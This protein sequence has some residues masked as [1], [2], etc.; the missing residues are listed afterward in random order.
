ML[1]IVTAKIWECMNISHS[2]AHCCY[3]TN[4]C[5]L[6][7]IS[8]MGKPHSCV[9]MSLFRLLKLNTQEGKILESSFSSSLLQSQPHTSRQ[10]SSPA[11]SCLCLTQLSLE[12]W[13]NTQESLAG[14]FHQLLR[15]SRLNHC[16]FKIS[17]TQSLLYY[18]LVFLKGLLGNYISWL[19]NNPLDELLIS[20]KESKSKRP[21][22]SSCLHIT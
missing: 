10:R 15:H 6:C 7:T 13:G 12:T 2:C 11:R 22:P 20:H 14:I 1:Q 3:L 18:C 19:S 21:F 8:Q 5:Q 16:R 17:M 9:K 4:K